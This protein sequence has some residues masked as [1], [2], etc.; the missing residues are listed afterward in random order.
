MFKVAEH[1]CGD[2]KLRCIDCNAQICPKCLVQCPV[3][4]RCKH[5]TQRFTSHVLQIDFW[6][7]VRS[8]SAAFVVGLLF[9]G[10]QTIFPLGGFYMLFLVY[11]LGS[12]AGNIIFKI[13]GR[14]L[15]PK[16]ATTVAAGL[17]AGSLCISFASQSLYGLVLKRMMAQNIATDS[18]PTISPANPYVTAPANRQNQAGTDPSQTNYAGSVDS[19]LNKNNP[20]GASPADISAAI[21]LAQARSG[22]A[23]S[24]ISL[25]LIIFILGTISP[26]MGWGNPFTGLF[27]RW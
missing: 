19:R 18:I 17:L 1:S 15:G 10:L 26:F 2:C 25:S 3:G 12:F 16:V 23:P 6:T 21:A 14:K 24:P 11:F 7:I 13:C 9:T 4:N 22:L 27:R 5:C 8:F 20:A